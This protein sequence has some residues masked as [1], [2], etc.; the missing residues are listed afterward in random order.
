MTICQDYHVP[1]LYL[2]PRHGDDSY[3]MHSIYPDFRQLVRKAVFEMRRR[4]FKNIAMLNSNSNNNV[5][6]FIKR[7]AAEAGLRFNVASY[8]RN[9]FDSMSRA[10]RRLFDVQEETV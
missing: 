2:A 8:Q 3:L 10:V 6:R 4:G 5:P 9:D 7:Y 1:I